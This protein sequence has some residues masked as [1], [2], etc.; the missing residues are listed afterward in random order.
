MSEAPMASGLGLSLAVGA[1]T[2]IGNG[3]AKSA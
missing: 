2:S 3:P 1:P